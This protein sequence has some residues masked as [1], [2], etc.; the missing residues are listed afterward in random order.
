M[1]AATRVTLFIPTLAGG[2]AEGA[3][4]NLAGELSNRQYDVYLVVAN[5]KGER[6]DEV[7][8]AVT[9]T[10]CSRS[11]LV[12]SL[13][14]LARHLRATAPDALISST[15]A[16]NLVAIWAVLLS[17]TSPTT[18]VRVE[19]MTSRQVENYEKRRYRAIPHLVKAFYDRPD[20]IVA[21]S[22][23]VAR[24]ISRIAGLEADDISV[25]YNPIVTP[26]LIRKAN[27][28]TDHPWLTD[29]SAPVILGVGRLTPQKDFSTLIRAFHRLLEHR[30]ARLVIAGK[31]EQRSDLNELAVDLEI[32]DRV[33]LPGFV[34]NQYAYMSNA[35]VFVLSS[36][37]EGFGNV[38]VE[39]MACGTPVVSTDCESGPEEILAGGR[40]GP[41]APVGRPEPL[42]TE[43]G[44]VLDNSIDEE[45]LRERA[46]DFSVQS[47]VDEY[48][49]LLT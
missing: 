4:L 34:P 21:V 19:N 5:A 1:T 25:I 44:N 22:R 42:A 23:G 38:L 13:P 14:D 37:W 9:V 12:A 8:E 31:G 3:M 40:Y 17:N 6:A 47:I 20:T 41:L 49:S 32:D 39:A 45:V 33:S 2:G 46:Q 11:S 27:Q 16:A 48:E 36:A 43:I 15:N 24:D 10:D 26:E 7:P 35:D 30:D 29:G 28:P 18:V